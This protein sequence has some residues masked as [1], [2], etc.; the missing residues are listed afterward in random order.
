MTARLIELD[1]AVESAIRLGV[2]DA[3]ADVVETGSTLRKAGLV[4]FGDPICE[5][6]AIVVSH[7]ELALDSANV[8][9]LLRRLDGVLV[10]RSYVMV[11]YNVAD[12]DLGAACALTPGLSG[13]TVSKLAREGWVA[14]RS[15]VPRADSQ[16]L[17]DDLYEVG[18]RG[19]L[20]TDLAA[21][22]L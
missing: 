2:A 14:V 5:S 3:I 16:R 17:L 22:R 7:D 1:G 20:L 6:E 11:D 13:P 19:I 18:A 12:D 4:V 15:L 9:Q 10:A 8:Q 21:C